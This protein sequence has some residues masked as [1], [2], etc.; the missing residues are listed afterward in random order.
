MGWYE[1]LIVLLCRIMLI[2]QK[3]HLLMYKD[4]LLPDRENR[5]PVKTFSHMFWEPQAGN[6]HRVLLGGD[7][8]PSG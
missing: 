8:L 4:D 7:I 2:F 5:L 6:L 1:C 3:I